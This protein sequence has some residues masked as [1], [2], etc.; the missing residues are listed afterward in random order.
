MRGYCKE[1]EV[2]AE[3]EFRGGGEVEMVK[4]EETR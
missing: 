1:K 3:G 4:V 2:E